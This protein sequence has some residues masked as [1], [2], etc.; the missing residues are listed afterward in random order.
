MSKWL[1]IL[2]SILIFPHR[3]LI[4]ENRLESQDSKNLDPKKISLEVCSSESCFNWK[5][6]D[7][8]VPLNFLFCDY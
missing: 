1:T 4:V 7:N 3:F 8:L 6:K 5:F 2:N